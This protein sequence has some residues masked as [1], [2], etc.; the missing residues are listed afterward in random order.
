MVLFK[1]TFAEEEIAASVAFAEKRDGQS[2]TFY[3]ERNTPRGKMVADTVCG[4]L[5]EFAAQRGLSSMFKGAKVSEV[6]LTLY[7]GVHKTWRPDL[8]VTFA[9]YPPIGV[10]VKMHVYG[11][12][13][14]VPVSFLFQPPGDGHHCDPH[15]KSIVPGGDCTEWFVGVAGY[16]TD[17]SKLK[18]DGTVK[19]DAVPDYGVMLGPYPMQEIVDKNLWRQPEAKRLRRQKIALWYEDLENYTH[20]ILGVD[21][22]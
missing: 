4:T 22:A 16:C 7:E 12:D 15:L 20:R 6:D 18:W 13:P 8:S 3:E 14:S 5:G 2:G 17:P 9:G 21:T 19:K 10:Q 11:R 1:H